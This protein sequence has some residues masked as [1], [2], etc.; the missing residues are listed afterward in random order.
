ME[1]KTNVWVLDNIKP[2]RTLESMVA[3]EERGMENRVMLG[4]VSGKRRRGRLIIRWLDYVMLGEMSGKRRRGRLIIRWLDIVS[5]TK[6]IH[7]Q[8]PFSGYETD[9]ST[10]GHSIITPYYFVSRDR[11]DPDVA[12]K[13]YIEITEVQ[14]DC[15]QRI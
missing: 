3:R 1:S 4:E 2:E 9:P 7:E 11:S 10:Y 8:F 5:F 12:I 15:L 6:M 14:P 13:A